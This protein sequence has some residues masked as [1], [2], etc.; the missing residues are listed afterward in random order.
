MTC[1]VAGEEPSTTTVTIA[2]GERLTPEWTS[3][4]CA[5]QVAP[6]EPPNASFTSAPSKPRTG[7]PV[8]FTST[9]TDPENAIALQEWDLDDD[10]QFDDA[11]GATVLWT[12]AAAGPRDVSLRVTDGGGAT[13]VVTR[14]LQVRGARG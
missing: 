9:S 10:G 7:Q 11:A 13:D 4:S 3:G 2:R 14:R 5:P 12:F 1:Q 8:T 6:N